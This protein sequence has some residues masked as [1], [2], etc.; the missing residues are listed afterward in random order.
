MAKEIWKRIENYPDYF[1][2]NFGRIKSYRW[3]KRTSILIPMRTPEGYVAI[4]FYK[5]GC[6]RKS[7]KI[8]RLVAKVFIPNPENKRCVNHKDGNK[9]NNHIENLEWMTKSE[10][11]KHAYKTGLKKY[12]LTNAHKA[13]KI[14]RKNRVV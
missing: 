4:Y 6:K 1:V 10:D 8:H 5:D 12:N 11:L 14:W 2:S 7:I 9:S 13:L 3:G